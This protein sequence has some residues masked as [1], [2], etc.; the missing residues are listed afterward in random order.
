MQGRHSVGFSDHYIEADTLTIVRLIMALVRPMPNASRAAAEEFLQGATRQLSPVAATSALCALTPAAR[1][2]MPA[3]Q[4]PAPPGAPQHAKRTLIH[5]RKGVDGASGNPFIRAPSTAAAAVVAEASA[6]L[7]AAQG[8]AQQAQQQQ[9][10]WPSRTNSAQQEQQDQQ[11][12]DLTADSPPASPPAGRRPAPPISIPP[13]PPHGSPQ[14]SMA[15]QAQQEQR[16]SLPGGSLYARQSQSA[17]YGAGAG[18]LPPAVSQHATSSSLQGSA[19]RPAAAQ[20]SQLG[21]GKPQAFYFP[22]H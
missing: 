15:Q 18:A 17:F 1:Q 3:Q 2:H 5:A 8:R 21:S 11:I 12:V 4:A 19:A 13:S 16:S 6:S 22:C 9:Y 7:T 10:S 14:R 20:S